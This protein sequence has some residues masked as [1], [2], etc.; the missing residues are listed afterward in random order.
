MPLFQGII[1]CVQHGRS[2]PQQHISAQ[3]PPYLRHCHAAGICRKRFAVNAFPFPKLLREGI[4]RPAFN[5]YR[6]NTGTIVMLQE[7]FDFPVDS[8]RTGRPRRADDNQPW[9]FGQDVFQLLCKICTAGH[10]PLVQKSPLERMPLAIR[11]ALSDRLRKPELLQHPLHLGCH[12]AVDSAMRITDK[13]V[14]VLV[15]QT[16]GNVRFHA[17]SFHH[18]ILSRAKPPCSVSGL[19]AL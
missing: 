2:N 5:Q 11:P 16:G 15:C 1:S 3:F 13:R 14:I 10:L 17:F 6:P 7:G 8:N 4:F 18:T 9:R 12:H 19:F